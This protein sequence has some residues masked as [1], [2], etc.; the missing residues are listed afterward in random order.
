MQNI[1]V[2]ILIILAVTGCKAEA[3]KTGSPLPAAKLA[4][5]TLV[6]ETLASNKPGIKTKLEVKSNPEIKQEAPKMITLRGTVRYKNFEGGFWGLDGNDGNKYVPS[7]LN[8]A[9][10]VDGMIVEVTGIIE[11]DKHQMTFQQYGKILKVKQS[12]MIDN[13]NARTP[14]SY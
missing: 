7:G 12:K 13:S 10:L 6:S 5:E 14:N 9:L 8:K 2:P 1:F 4:S 3:E 11:D